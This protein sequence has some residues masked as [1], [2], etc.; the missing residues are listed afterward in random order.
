MTFQEFADGFRRFDYNNPDFENMGSWP[1]GLKLVMLV[2]L[3]GLI[4]F[5]FYWFAIKDSYAQLDRDMAREPSLKQ[6]YQSKA[7]RVANLDSFKAQ[8][9]EMEESF[10]ALLSQL[11]DETEM[12]GLLDDIS[13]TGTQ[14]G[15]EIDRITPNSDVVREF[16]IE[17]PIAIQV[18]GT[19]HEMGTFVSAMSAIPRIVTLH[20][21]T[22]NASNSRRGDSSEAEMESPLS[23]TINARTYRYNPGGAQ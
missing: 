7:F 21:F 20:D 4:V 9:A 6:E 23:M 17:T 14:S 16:Y 18:R 22:L 12:P 2:I 5:G 11:P 15:L 3:A 19:Y 1:F 13:T 10:G 8:L